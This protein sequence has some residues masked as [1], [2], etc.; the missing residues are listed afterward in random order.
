MM[1]QADVLGDLDQLASRYDVLRQMGHDGEYGV[2]AVRSRA[3][4]RH[5]AV[6]VMNDPGSRDARKGALYI[7]QAHTIRPLDHPHLTVLHAVHHLQGGAVAIAME[8]R[9]GCT[10]AERIEQTGPLPIHEVERVLRD[11]GGALAYVHGH[12]AVH[13]G[14]RPHSIFLDRDS[15]EARL[16]PFGLDRGHG[17]SDPSDGG[18]ATLRAF[19]YL[20]PEQIA[21]REQV[22]GRQLGPCT[23]LYGLG[24]AGYAMLT[25][26]QPWAG[27]DLDD[28]LARRDTEP[29]P[30][31]RAL[32]PDAPAY[33]CDAIEG[34]LEPDPRRRWRSADA[35]LACLDPSTPSPTPAL[36][37]TGIGLRV[38]DA[39]AA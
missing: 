39:V 33:L 30:P 15:G 28:L 8:R 34:C 25:G 26:V 20:A 12:R 16:A 29:L 6:K 35:F 19:S 3:S 11:V 14:V 7:W 31:L 1:N 36:D 27:T 37:L 10:L 22:E 23:D 13:R 21:G 5:F 2:H 9:R 18:A 24:L 17:D 38:A 32:R 4:N